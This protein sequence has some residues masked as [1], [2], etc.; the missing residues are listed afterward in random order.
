MIFKQIKAEHIYDM[1]PIEESAFKDP[2]DY[3]IL[4]EEIKINPNSNYI[5]LFI[6][7][8]II[9]YIGYWFMVD[10]FDIA[11]LAVKEGYKNQ[12]LA[13]KLLLE[14]ERLAKEAGVNNIFLEVSV[15]NEAAINLYLKHD[16]KKL[17]IIKNYYTILKEDAFLMQKEVYN[18]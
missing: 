17:K 12:G 9:A 13:S 5:G 14:I 18:G 15:H 16:Y 6:E 10:Y 2:W 8:E 7:D 1:L 3:K 4:Y 11:N